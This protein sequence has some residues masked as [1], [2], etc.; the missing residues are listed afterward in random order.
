[1]TSSHT[2][3]I[4][5]HLTKRYGAF[6]AV[7]DLSFTVDSGEIFGLL[8]PNGAGKTTTIRMIMDIFHADAGQITLLG[9]APGQTVHRVGYLPEERGLYQ[10]QRI[11][12][13]LIFLA[14]LK[15]LTRRAAQAQ[16]TRWLE[17]VELADRARDQVNSLSRGMQQKLQIAASLVHNPDIVILDEP[18]QGLDPVNV[19]LVKSIMREAQAAGKSVVLSAHQMNLVEALCDRILML[20][21]GRRVLYG[22]LDEVKRDY[23]PNV[24]RIRTPQPLPLDQLEGVAKV[25]E[26]GR[27]TLITL[28]GLQPQELLSWL[29]QQQI[30]L[31][32]FEVADT[33][34]DE[35]FVNIVRRSNGSSA[36]TPLPATA[37][38]D[39]V[40]Q[41][42]NRGGNR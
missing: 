23:A 35:I 17:R 18:F 15:G 1:V 7:D 6:T 37:Q 36:A 2:T 27:D 4:V 8:G 42:K 16:T 38:A 33:P 14:Q 34:L 39:T 40:D 11:A 29:V 24:V 13:V 41:D 31:L 19:D 9:A 26:Q 3:L 10:D 32:R 21:R 30:E 28:A 22:T 20:N 25:E 5:E 12:D